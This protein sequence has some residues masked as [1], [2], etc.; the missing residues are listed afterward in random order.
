MQENADNKLSYF[1]DNTDGSSVY[2]MKV[3]GV[4]IFAARA[5]K[6]EEGIPIYIRAEKHDAP[7]IK[8]SSRAFLTDDNSRVSAMSM[9]EAVY[10]NLVYFLI[11]LVKN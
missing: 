6:N 4:V 3:N 5:H 9:K 7:W 2:Q 11:E 1:S 10:G 8:T